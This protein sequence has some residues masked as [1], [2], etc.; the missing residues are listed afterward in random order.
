MWESEKLA[1]I[2]IYQQRE[3][4]LC[5]EED[6]SKDLGAEMAQQRRALVALTEDLDLIPRTH[7]EAHSC[8]H[9]KSGNPITSSVLCGYQAHTWCTNLHAGKTLIHTQQK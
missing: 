7:K 9:L 4:S 6:E 1:D 5:M 2:W 3:F 8:L